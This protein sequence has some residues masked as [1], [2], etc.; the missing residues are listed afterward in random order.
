MNRFLT[1][2]LCVFV[3][4]CTPH[5]DVLVVGGGAS[6]AVAGIE[7]SRLGLKAAI[8]EEGPWLGGALTSAGV[9]A[10]D[11]NYRLRAGIFGEFVDSL[12]ARYGGLEALKTGWVS[13]VLYEPH[14]G[15]EV[16]RN[17]AP[18]NL[19]L[20]FH[21]RLEDVRKLNR[22]WEVTLGRDGRAFRVRAD[23]LIDGTELGD[24]AKACGASYEVGYADTGI[25]QDITMVLTVKDYGEDRSI[26]MPEGYDPERYA[27]CCRNPLNR[28]SDKGQALWSPGM[29]LSYG[30][31]PGGKI[32]LNWP[33]EGNDFYAEMV[34]ASRE[35]RDS[36][37]N[38]AK[39]HTLGFLYFIQHELGY[40]NIG[41]CYDEYP[42]EDGFPLIPY[43]RESRRINGVVR[44]TEEDIANPYRNLLYQQGV[45]V[46]DYP[47]DHHHFQ[48][49]DWKTLPKAYGKIPSFT[50]PM[51]VMIPSDVKD[52]IVAD[53]S[54]SVSCIANGTTRLQP[55]LMELGQAAA[56]LAMKSLQMGV[57]PC[58]VPVLEVQK[59]LL[60]R[61]ARIQPYL[62]SNPEDPDFIETQLAGTRGEIKAEGRNE[63][64]SN[65]MWLIYDK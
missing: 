22:G 3:C 45:A 18:D 34:E 11:G 65:E 2:L 13:N 25:V 48:R 17:M 21:T 56:V 36:L 12:A 20:M 32:M 38:A 50:V 41:I 9:S 28:E 39:S 4:S 53:K 57:S 29:M 43:H 37:V 8:A 14:V 23:I 19:N 55:V 31:L 27:N 35:Q 42:T 26:P 59:I 64:W 49:S 61:G 40:N 1:I 54:I 51:G 10:I 33:I 60:E 58:D 6:G 46:G 63:G 15:A 5:Y 7:A 44:F 24:L 30:A 16:L 52:L 47:I 62:N